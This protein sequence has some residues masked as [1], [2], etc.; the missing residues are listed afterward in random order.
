MKTMIFVLFSIFAATSAFAQNV[1]LRLV[2]Q[3]KSSCKGEIAPIMVQLEDE[4]GNVLLLNK[5]VTLST[6]GPLKGGPQSASVT[7]MSGVAVFP[8]LM[9]SEDVIGLKLVAI[10]P[11]AVPALSNPFDV[12]SSVCLNGAGTEIQD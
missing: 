8:Q 5:P 12:G 3:P 10:A 7:A 6:V 11:G 9:V 4:D 1:N 2:N